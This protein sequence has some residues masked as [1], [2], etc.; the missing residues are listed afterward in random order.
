M[1]KP[2]A[3]NAVEHAGEHPRDATCHT[4]D[5]HENDQTGHCLPER[6]QAVPHHIEN[7]LP[8]V[9]GQ[10]LRREEL[11]E[12][13]TQPDIDQPPHKTQGQGH[14]QRH[15]RAQRVVGPINP[16]NPVR[17]RLVGHHR[18]HTCDQKPPGAQS[19]P[20]REQQSG[21]PKGRPADADPEQSCFV[22]GEAGA[23]RI[24]QQHPRAL[25]EFLQGQARVRVDIAGKDRQDRIIPQPQGDGRLAIPGERNR[26]DQQRPL[27]SLKRLQ[28]AQRPVGALGRR[29]ATD[30]GP[31]RID[32]AVH[33]DQV[34][35]RQL[36]VFGPRT[37]SG[38]TH[39]THE[40][41]QN[42]PKQR[43]PGM[44]SRGPGSPEPTCAYEFAVLHCSALH[45]FGPV[46][47]LHPIACGQAR[48]GIPP[49]ACARSRILD[50]PLLPRKQL[51]P[52]F[53]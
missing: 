41:D 6:L 40:Y 16:E 12:H 29:R 9:C 47:G 36:R 25:G 28:P 34:R 4:C 14:G 22:E 30:G 31:H 53:G 44:P 32:Q 51:P 38:Q 27:P 3:F 33:V 1:E 35:R 37:W 2:P 8:H 5:Q 23:Q 13:P 46:N 20:D 52:H 26:I 21:Q 18:L 49:G 7:E 50:G 39:Q 24:L 11:I 19:H 45:P 42:P 15:Q 17:R 10:G 43:P 48:S